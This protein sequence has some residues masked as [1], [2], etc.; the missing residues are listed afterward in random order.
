MASTVVWL[1]TIEGNIY[2]AMLFFDDGTMMC[3]GY[4]IENNGEW[5]ATSFK[6][7]TKI[8]NSFK[9]KQEAASYILKEC[10]L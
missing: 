1:K 8:S 2:S 9:T 5:S 10:G 7:P 6:N 4:A 3:I